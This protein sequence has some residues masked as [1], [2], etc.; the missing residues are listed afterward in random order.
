MVPQ[1]P[2]RQNRG[3]G[4]PSNM[5]HM[6]RPYRFRCGFLGG[7]EMAQHLVT[8]VLTL[9]HTIGYKEKAEKSGHEIPYIIYHMEHE[10]FRC[11]V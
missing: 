4:A 6:T 2:C 8:K 7:T 9:A 10:R 11:V 1:T 5:R 3:Q